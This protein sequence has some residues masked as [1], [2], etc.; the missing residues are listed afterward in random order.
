M[1]E[2][3]DWLGVDVGWVYPAVDSDGTIYRWSKPAE[4][5]QQ[6]RDMT[7]AGPVKI[8]KADG[9]TRIRDPYT[10]AQL[11]D[12]NTRADEQKVGLRMHIIAKRIISTAAKTSRGV[13]LEDW[14]EVKRRRTAWVRVYTAV[15]K[16]AAARGVPLRTTDRAWTSLTCPECDFVDRVNR[17]QRDRFRCGNCG[18]QGQADTIAA[19]N[20]RLRALRLDR[21]H[22]DRTAA[23]AN[24]ACR[25]PN[26]HQ[27]GRC[28]RCFW[29][30]RRY[31]RFPTKEQLNLLQMA[32]NYPRFVQLNDGSIGTPLDVNVA[33]SGAKPSPEPER[34]FDWEQY[35]KDWLAGKT[36][37]SYY[38][39][40]RIYYRDS[41]Q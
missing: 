39:H 22:D 27:G 24:P 40:G 2:P 15:V 26:V 20:I 8:T 31:G 36:S 5:A 10:P 21:I 37:T 1:N 33:R 11:A 12:L 38:F 17:L 32:E 9:T 29:F 35:Q 16:E 34:L 7:A 13:A 30:V 4:R 6:R 41:D 3:V 23:C 14:E 18:H 25:A 19:Q 28:L